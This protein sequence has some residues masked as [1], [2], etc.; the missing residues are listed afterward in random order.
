MQRNVLTIPASTPFSEIV[1]LL[2]VAGIHGAPVLDE[3]GAVVGLISVMD[4]LRA[5]DQSHDDEQDDGE[6]ATPG[7]QLCSA[8]A[9]ELASPELTW[10]SPETPAGEVARVM[11]D[12]GIHRVLVGSPGSLDGI[13]TAFDLLRAVPVTS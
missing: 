3:H 13:V 5:S 2:V 9:R 6:G 12:E 4:L 1:R 7:T 11:R 8:T 10:V